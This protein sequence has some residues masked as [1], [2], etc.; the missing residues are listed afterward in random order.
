MLFRMNFLVVAI[1]V[2]TNNEYMLYYICAM[3][4]YWFFTVYTFMRVLTSWNTHR[5]RM[6]A[7]FAAYI[8]FNALIFEIP[9]VCSQLFRPL[10][11]VFQFH[12]NK[13]ELMHEWE[14]RAG[15][16]H[17][18]CLCGML[19]AY[20]YPHYEAFIKYL[21]RNSEGKKAA[22]T[23]LG[24]KLGMLAAA[25]AAGVFWYVAFMR[26]EKFTYN[27]THCYTSLIPI[28]IYIVV[29]NLFPTLRRYHVGL[30]ASLGKITLE[31]YLSQLH[32]YLQSNAK[33]LIGYIP[34]YPLLNFAIATIV[35]LTISQQL[36]SLT[37]SFSAFFVQKD[38]RKAARLTAVAAG[39]VAASFLLS[40]II[41]GNERLL[42]R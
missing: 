18:A 4:T 5:W 16:D 24:I 13:H 22:T 2:V 19:C 42:V 6:A 20:N 40:L 11:F 38:W 27:A 10:W 17:W 1:V 33:H 36:F 15:L 29:R 9:G 26:L 21:E 34:G 23:K 30:F 32:V 31:T 39:V 25:V 14:F 12:D 28:L 41:K 8:F 37:L 3:H 7:K 35:Y